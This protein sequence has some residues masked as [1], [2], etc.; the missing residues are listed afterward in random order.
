MTWVRKIIGRL[1][2]LTMVAADL[3]GF[4]HALQRDL[5]EITAVRSARAFEV[6]A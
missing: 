4:C 2:L 3:D 5:H 6:W 1:T